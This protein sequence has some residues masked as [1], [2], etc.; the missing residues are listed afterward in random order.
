MKNQS[1]GYRVRYLLYYAD[2]DYLEMCA[3]LVV[4]LVNPLASNLMVMVPEWYDVSIKISGLA[5]LFAVLSGVLKWR[6]RCLLL[7]LALHTGLLCLEM[8]H[9]GFQNF[10]WLILV[11][12]IVIAFCTI[13]VQK[14]SM[15][16]ARCSK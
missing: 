10:L 13:R 6:F 2:S 11:E 8:H 5:L 14:E 15:H 1:A 16:A 3:A 12:W 4:L 9:F 7:A